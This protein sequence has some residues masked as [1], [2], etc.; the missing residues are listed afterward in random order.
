MVF[1]NQG[2]LSPRHVTYEKSPV[3]TGPDTRAAAVGGASLPRTHAGQGLRADGAGV[4]RAPRLWEVH[5]R[6]PGSPATRGQ[7]PSLV[8]LHRVLPWPTGVRVAAQG[9]LCPALRVSEV[10]EDR[11]GPASGQGNGTHASS[12]SQVGSE[13][14]PSPGQAASRA[15][16]PG[17]GRLG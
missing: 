12:A 13:P 15:R 5:P 16:D 6:R 11:A 7:C 9:S 3:G 8:F 10:T 2:Q 4:R 14:W 17:C 1:L